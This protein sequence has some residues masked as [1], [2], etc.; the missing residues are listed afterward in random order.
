MIT[1]LT[2]SFS[3]AISGLKTTWDEE[4]NFKIEVVLT[5]LVLGLMFYF[6]FS[7]VEKVFCI[8]AITIVLSSEVINT[9]IEDLCNKVEPHTD[10]V[11]K[12]IKD[13]SSGFVLISSLGAFIVGVL[14]FYSHFS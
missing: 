3:Y 4:S 5:V 11:I 10:P 7:L 8:L 14:V 6:D 9:A 1:K 2:N 12:K 13:V